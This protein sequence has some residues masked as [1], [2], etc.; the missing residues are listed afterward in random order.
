MT[1]GVIVPQYV[2][3]WNTLRTTP[4]LVDRDIAVAIGRD[5]LGPSDPG[6]DGQA[7]VAAGAPV[8]AAGE[9]VDDV[10]GSDLADRVV[11][12]SPPHRR[13]PDE[14]TVTPSG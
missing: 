2:G 6:I 7:A 4:L 8:A 10:A 12:H 9:P 13:L 1:V 3:P 11:A 14:S 5:I